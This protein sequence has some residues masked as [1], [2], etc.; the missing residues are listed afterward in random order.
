MR[1]RLRLRGVERFI[2]LLGVTAAGTCERGSAAPA[3]AERA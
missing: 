1:S 3:A 2:D